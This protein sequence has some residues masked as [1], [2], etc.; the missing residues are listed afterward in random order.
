MY[1][2]DDLNR[3][4]AAGRI[5]A[6][7]ARQFQLFMAES[8]AVR[9]ADEERFRLVTSFSDVFVLLASGMLL[10]AT[11]ILLGYTVGAIACA[12]LAWGLAE[13]FI[14]G[15]RMATPSI[16]YAFVWA[17][18]PAMA[19]LRWLV[20]R[21][22]FDRYA[23]FNLALAGALVAVLAALFWKRFRVPVAVT[24]IVGG[25][26]TCLLN[27][28]L[29]VWSPSQPGGAPIFL[30]AGMAVFALA[31]RFDIKDRQRTTL[32]AD[33][34]FWLHLLAASLAVHSI[35]ALL[36]NANFSR[37]SGAHTLLVLFAFL[38]LMSV[39]LIIDRRAILVAAAMYVVVALVA[40][41]EQSNVVQNSGAVVAAFV[42]AFFLLLSWGWSP[43]RRALLKFV[44]APIASRLPAAA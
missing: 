4:V 2:D 34:A 7:A 9:M 41:L 39:A 25:I 15:K 19:L 12:V 26:V 6:E 3:A 23:Q 29:G 44:P 40:S 14:R 13:I 10:G 43:A 42:G 11:G 38:I 18:A 27:L 33:I 28:L 36:G 24:L 35:F 8:R 20:D 16:V 31:M 30:L 1:T 17:I 5:D 21:N 37:G 32:N 22:W